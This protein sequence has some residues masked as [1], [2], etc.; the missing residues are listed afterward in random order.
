MRYQN[1]DNPE[2]ATVLLAED[3]DELRDLLAFCFYQ[4]G[5]S[6]T[7]CADGQSLLAKVEESLSGS[8]HPIDLV[9]TDIRMPGLTGLDVLK[10][11]ES[12]PDIPPVICM[13]AFGDSQTHSLA[14]RL[15]AWAILDK[16]FDIGKIIAAARTVCPPHKS[17][18]ERLPV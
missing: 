18:S 13:T 16:P 3:D 7:S 9:V 4:Q 2:S 14:K 12:H 1:L 11:L 15:R 8:G 10:A 5:Y 17:N 6:V